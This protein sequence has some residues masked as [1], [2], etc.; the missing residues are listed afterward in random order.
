MPRYSKLVAEYSEYLYNLMVGNDK[1]IVLDA[2]LVD[3]FG[4][5][6]IKDDFPDRFVE[7]GISEQHMVSMANGIALS[8]YYPVCHTYG[9]FY[10][11][12]I[13]QIYNNYK[14]GLK[15][16]YVAGMVWLNSCSHNYFPAV[17]ILPVR[18]SI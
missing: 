9:A 18:T 2:D 11:R 4:L 1:V 10:R 7:C 15:I 8:G 6:K 12:A 5:R 16:T 14:D 13:D 3:D 17:A